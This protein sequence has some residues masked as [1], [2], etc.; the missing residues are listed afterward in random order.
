[1]SYAIEE[2]EGVGPAKAR[3]LQE[4]GIKTTEDLLTQAGSAKG[5]EALAA[6]T[7]L[8]KAELLSYVN[9][10]DLM[11][12]H[13]VGQEFS[14]LLEK[15]GVDTVKELAHRV[16]AN[17]HAKLEATAEAHPRMVRRVPNAAEVA[18]WVTEAK[19]L[20]ARVTH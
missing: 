15:A 8:R 6:A 13:G 10:A 3:L 18:K 16:P 12:L 19:T 1:M 7:G 9:F 14:E 11:R 4:A 5:R 2:I 17:L 20:E